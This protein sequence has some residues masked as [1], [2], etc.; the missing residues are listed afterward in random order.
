MPLIDRDHSVILDIQDHRR[1]VPS[2]LENSGIPGP[3]QVIASICSLT[4]LAVCIVTNGCCRTITALPKQVIPY[5]DNDSMRCVQTYIQACDGNQAQFSHQ[6][7]WIPQKLFSTRQVPPKRIL[8]LASNKTNPSQ[9][10]SHHRWF[11]ETG[12]RQNRAA[13]PAPIETDP[14]KEH[15]PSFTFGESDALGPVIHGSNSPTPH[16]S[17][18]EN[19]LFG[20]IA[21]PIIKTLAGQIQKNTQP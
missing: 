20:Y 1:F 5:I 19:S 11:P 2:A 9:T 16:L 7:T 10:S 8:A 13:K 15:L 21:C 14:D 6:R 12:K 18:I 17:L 4:S 3:K